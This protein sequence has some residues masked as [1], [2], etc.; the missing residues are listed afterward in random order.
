MR[1]L[2]EHGSDIF[3]SGPTASS[4]VATIRVGNENPGL[5]TLAD[6]ANYAIKEALSVQNS[7]A[8]MFVVWALLFGCDWRGSNS[9]ND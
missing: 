7:E 3:Y 4:I 1:R 8:M 5:I 6:L 2:A 9:R